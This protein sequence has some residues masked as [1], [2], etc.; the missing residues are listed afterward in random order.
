M[1]IIE[2]NQIFRT[3]SK[4]ATMN[5][6]SSRSQMFYK[7]GVLKI[8]QNSQESTCVRGLQLH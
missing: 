4:N 1:T 3:N 2:S 5:V 6:E 7:I 8:S